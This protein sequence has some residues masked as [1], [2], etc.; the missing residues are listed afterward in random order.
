MS[1]L[2]PCP[3]C[4]SSDIRID[5]HPNYKADI[6]HDPSNEKFR[7]IYSMCCY[8]CGATFPNRYKRELLVENWNRRAAWPSEN[9]PQLVSEDAK[10]ATRYRALFTIEDFCRNPLWPVVDWMRDGENVNKPII[11]EALDAVIYNK[12]S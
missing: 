3:F 1:E 7:Y 10:D 8:N 12:E 11:D 6:F 9:N 5:Q 4:A 2:L